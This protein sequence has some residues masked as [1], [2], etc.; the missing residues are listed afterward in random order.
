M[1]SFYRPLFVRISGHHGHQ[2]AVVLPRLALSYFV[3]CHWQDLLTYFALVHLCYRAV[4]TEDEEQEFAV[5][6]AIVQELNSKKKTWQRPVKV[7]RAEYFCDAVHLRDRHRGLLIHVARVETFAP[8]LGKNAALQEDDATI[9]RLADLVMAVI[10]HK[11]SNAGD[12]SNVVLAL[13]ASFAPTRTLSAVAWAFGRRH[14]ASAA[15]AGFKGIWLVGRD[16]VTTYR[17][18]G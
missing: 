1:P 18:A 12:R 8:D 17:L 16:S 11:W 13:D 2:Q 15:L 5:C 3:D 7:A 4:S 10:R 14:G 6:S 9:H